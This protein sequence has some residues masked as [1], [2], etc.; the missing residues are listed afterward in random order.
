MKLNINLVK[1]TANGIVISNDY[2]GRTLSYYIGK[3]C[4][5]Y[6][7]ISTVNSKGVKTLYSYIGFLF[8]YIY[9][10]AFI[11]LFIPSI[12]KKKIESDERKESSYEM[13]FNLDN[14]AFVILHFNSS[15]K[16]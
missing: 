11:C 8:N 14:E 5:D 9:I 7:V 3:D 6:F 15:L 13:K 2:K 1:N 12:I 16:N 4:E 10:I